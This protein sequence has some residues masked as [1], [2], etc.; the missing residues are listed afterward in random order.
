MWLAEVWGGRGGGGSV[1]DVPLLSLPLTVLILALFTGSLLPSL[2]LQGSEKS[3]TG[4]EYETTAGSVRPCL[5]LSLSK[6][7]LKGDR[8]WQRFNVGLLGFECQLV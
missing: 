6:P 7:G 1:G 5:R 2:G 4:D 8:A 3:L